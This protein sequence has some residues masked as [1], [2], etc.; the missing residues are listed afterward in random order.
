MT[1]PDKTGMLLPVAASCPPSGLQDCTGLPSIFVSTPKL[2]VSW[3]YAELS[4]AEA[5]VAVR[6]VWRCVYGSVEALGE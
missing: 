6:S 5:C 3:A 2:P 4:F 1:T